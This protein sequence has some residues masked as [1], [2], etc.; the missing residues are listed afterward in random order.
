MTKTIKHLVKLS[1]SLP[2][3]ILACVF[4]GGIISILSVLGFKGVLPGVMAESLAGPG[5]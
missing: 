5:N 3:W 4:V 1:S 2:I